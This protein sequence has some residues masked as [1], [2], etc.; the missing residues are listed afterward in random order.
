MKQFA[1]REI[2][3]TFMAFVV[4]TL[5]VPACYALEDDGTSLEALSVGIAI[6][7]DGK[8][9]FFYSESNDNIDNV[10][11]FYYTCFH[12]LALKRFRS[13]EHISRRKR[14]IMC[15]CKLR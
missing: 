7:E 12:W 2:I 13:T 3:I 14:S 8:R 15:G 11:G 4:L 5:F 6:G 10:V 1:I 9:C